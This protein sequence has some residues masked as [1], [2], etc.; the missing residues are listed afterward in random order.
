LEIRAGMEEQIAQLKAQ[1][2]A[3]VTRGNVMALRR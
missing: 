1:L 2:E 3:A